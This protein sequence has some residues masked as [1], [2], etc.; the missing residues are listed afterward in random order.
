MKKT[1]ILLSVLVSACNGTQTPAVVNINTSGGSSSTP[2]TLNQTNN[3]AS[4]DSSLTSPLMQR[5]ISDDC[6]GMHVVCAYQSKGYENVD[7]ELTLNPKDIA[8]DGTA[9]IDM[10]LPNQVFEKNKSIQVG[11]S[12]TFKANGGNYRLAILNV[13]MDTSFNGLGGYIKFKLTNY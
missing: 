6:K 7:I 4:Q 3:E 1:L 11:D 2:I 5:T 9:T 10:K 8:S 13:V 12:W